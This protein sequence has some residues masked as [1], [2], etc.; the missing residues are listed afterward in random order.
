MVSKKNAKNILFLYFLTLYYINYYLNLKLFFYKKH[1]SHSENILFLT[2]NIL[3]RYIFRYK[4][5]VSTK[6]KS[7]K[8]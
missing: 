2:T 4:K 8:K 7:I 5:P 3:F 1:I 6:N